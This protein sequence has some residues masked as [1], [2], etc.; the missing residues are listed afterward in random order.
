MASLEG[1]GVTDLHPLLQKAR[2]CNDPERRRRLLDSY[3]R[4]QVAIHEDGVRGVL[5]AFPDTRIPCDDLY[6]RLFANARA[7]CGGGGDLEAEEYFA[8]HVPGI[9][10]DLWTTGSLVGLAKAHWAWDKFEADMKER[11]HGITNRS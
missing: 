1:G 5:R 11:Y 9:L 10:E 6:H 7:A 2:E 4:Q 8:E 3:K